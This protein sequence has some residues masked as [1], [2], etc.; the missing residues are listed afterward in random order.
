MKRFLT[1]LLASLPRG[2]RFF[3]LIY[4]LA[5]PAALILHFAH[6]PDLYFWS[7]LSPA[8][9][10][11]G[12]IWR[13][14]TYGFIANG[15]VE[16]FITLFWL[17]TL[18]SIVGRSWSGAEFWSFCLL[19]M[20]AGALPFVIARPHMTQFIVGGGAVTFALLVAWDWFHRNERLLLLGLG[21]VSV[22]Q[23]AILIAIIN[24]VVLFFCCCGWFFMVSMWCG[25]IA[26]WL[27]LVIRSKM[28]LGKSPRQM[29]SERV[30]RLE[31]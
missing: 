16:W 5:F 15:P 13:M 10:W 1:N 20:F 14:F 28:I 2:P 26:G 21:E 23:A 8:K 22:R 29:R 3:L 7:G 11:S 6:G 24:S 9:V 12:Q 17:A 25:G 4:A 27:H 19:A 30:A 18:C 31:L